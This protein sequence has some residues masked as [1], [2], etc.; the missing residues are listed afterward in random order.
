VRRARLLFAGSALGALA[1]TPALAA[2][3][4][5]EALQSCA[6]VVA[7]AERLACFDKLFGHKPALSPPA[8]THPGAAGAAVAPVVAPAATKDAFGL[9]AAEHPATPASGLES[10]SAR[11]VAFGRSAKLRPTV[12]LEGNQLWEL[13]ES[14][15]DPLLSVGDLVTIQRAALGSFVL[16]TPA[17]RT[18]RV[19]RLR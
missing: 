9:Y 18:H 3:P 12:A 10:I 6:A 15:A 7:D 14:D 1:A 8:P 4:A 2:L 11:V 13:Q 16:T 19:R 17:K 5:A